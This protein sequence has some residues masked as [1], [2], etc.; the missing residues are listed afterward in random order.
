MVKSLRTGVGLEGGGRKA[1]ME[2]L[3]GSG[4]CSVR[5]TLWLLRLCPREKLTLNRSFLRDV[6]TF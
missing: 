5:S 1:G 2:L 4:N 6:I 3:G